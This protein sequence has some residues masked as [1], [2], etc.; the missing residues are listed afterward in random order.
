MHVIDQMVLRLSSWVAI[1]CVLLVMDLPAHSQGRFRPGYVVL[2]SGDSAHG[3]ISVRGRSA[4]AIIVAFKERANGNVRR[5][6]PTAVARFGW[7][8]GQKGIAAAVYSVAHHQE[9]FEEGFD[10]KADTSETRFQ[11][12]TV[13]ATGRIATLYQLIGNSDAFYISPAN[14]PDSLTPLIDW[15]DRHQ[16]TFPNDGYDEVELFQS[17][18]AA[19]AS[20]RDSV[21]ALLPAV[22]CDRKHLIQ[23]VDIINGGAIKTKPS[24]I[25]LHHTVNMWVGPGVARIEPEY[26]DDADEQLFYRSHIVPKIGMGL[27]VPIGGPPARSY[28]RFEAGWM[29]GRFQPTGGRGPYW[30]AYQQH[31]MKWQALQLAVSL[32]IS[33][34]PHAIKNWA[35]YVGPQFSLFH[36]D[37]SIDNLKS[38]NNPIRGTGTAVQA[39]AIVR[40]RNWEVCADIPLEHMSTPAKAG[41][42]EV[43]ATVLSFTINYHF[44]PF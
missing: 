36:A 34:L 14:R 1:C 31:G 44:N 24:P 39:K 9:P 33:I 26:G 2:R 40:F 10:Q 18:L 7:D 29:T 41:P 5:F 27:D 17:Q 12:L 22:D 35:F 21:L 23:I 38:G 15:I 13:L 16:G 32:N 42:D 25:P 20:D 8:D 43:H 30:Q 6:G 4:P 19:F 3:W 28:L 11:F 37:V